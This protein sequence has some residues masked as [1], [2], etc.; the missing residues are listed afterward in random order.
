MHN[1]SP[2]LSNQTEIN[3]VSIILHF[4]SK[5]P[6]DMSVILF[7]T[8]LSSLLPIYFPLPLLCIL[9]AMPLIPSKT[10]AI[11]STAIPLHISTNVP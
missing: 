1:V 7:P 5:N 2:T 6:Y 9:A 11:T 10:F 3:D 8:P 4:L